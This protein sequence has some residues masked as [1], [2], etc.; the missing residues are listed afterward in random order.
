MGLRDASD[1]WNRKIKGDT[2]YSALGGKDLYVEDI[3]NSDG[4][5]MVYAGRRDDV[6]SETSGTIYIRT[7]EDDPSKRTI[8][9][10]ISSGRTDEF[11][12]T[13]GGERQF[14]VRDETAREMRMPGS[15]GDNRPRASSDCVF[16]L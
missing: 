12:L 3:P 9:A 6:A 11:V 2:D 8:L 1:E 13:R 14:Q 5:V 10:S 15:T 7:N 4:L 16:F